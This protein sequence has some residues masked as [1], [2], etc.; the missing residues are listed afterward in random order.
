MPNEAFKKLWR[1]WL[2]KE[3]ILAHIHS[4]YEERKPF[5]NLL[6]ACVEKVGLKDV[7]VLE[8]GCGTAIDA[9]YLTQFTKA[10]VFATDISPDAIEVAKEIGKFFGCKIS[11]LVD[12]AT[13]MHF[14]DNSFDIVFSQGV[15]EHFEDPKPVMKEQIRVWEYGWETEYSYGDLKKMGKCLGLKLVDVSAHGYGY[16]QDYGFGY[17]R[18][19]GEKIQRKSLL[20]RADFFVFILGRLYDSFWQRLEKRYGYYFMQNISVVFQKSD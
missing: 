9:Y 14:P 2:A 3:D 20:V 10:E 6:K 18:M 13:N 19:L 17:I 5:L 7:K 1:D 4:H 12:D 11:L 16:D 8:I 15:I